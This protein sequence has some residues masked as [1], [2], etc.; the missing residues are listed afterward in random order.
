MRP[1]INF[2]DDTNTEFLGQRYLE[3]ASL[4]RKHASLSSVTCDLTN[5]QQQIDK[6]IT[7]VSELGGTELS[8]LAFV[9]RSNVGKS[10]LIN[11]LL[12]V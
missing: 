12:G 7:L 6:E 10:S 11:A 4:V 3:Q 5:I 9:G 8:D 1:F 2:M